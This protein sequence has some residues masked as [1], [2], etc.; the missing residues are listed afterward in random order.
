[1]VKQVSPPQLATFEQKPYF[2]TEG[3]ATG[4]VFEAPVNGATTP[5]SPNPRSELRQLN[6][7]GSNAEWSNKNETWI[8]DVW[9]KFT[10][11]PNSSDPTRG[12]VGMQIH[13]GVD[14]VSVLRYERSGDLYVT[15]GDD[16][17]WKKIDDNHKLNTYM[18]VR[19]EAR[20][21]GGIH[22]YRDGVQVAAFP[23]V[24]SGCYFKTGCYT[25]GNES[26][27]TGKGQVVIYYFKWFKVV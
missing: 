27:S 13:D 2:Y 11:A 25:Q 8:M 26:N 3:A 5:N 14:D 20:K 23:G 17:H 15:R 4:V 10:V 18:K 24:F 12:V 21:G 7:D 9:L 6:G 19:V 16:S 1:M 22:W